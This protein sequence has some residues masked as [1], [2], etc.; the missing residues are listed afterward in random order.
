MN[1]PFKLPNQEHN[2]N[3]RFSRSGEE[4][5]PGTPVFRK[6]L[7]DDILGEANDDGTIYL[8]TSLEP[9]SKEE[10]HVL[11]HEMVHMTQMKTGKLSYE[12]DKVTWNGDDY[13]RENGYI[14]YEG[15]KYPEGSP[16]LPWEKMPWGNNTII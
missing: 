5:V 10:S 8:D 6:K 1:K 13:P 15:E 11:M 7:G 2:K 4:A 3:G 14:L 16:E 9:G 12:D